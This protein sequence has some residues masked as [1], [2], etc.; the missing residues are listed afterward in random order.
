MFEMTPLASGFCIE[1]MVGLVINPCSE[2][3][4]RFDALTGKHEDAT[5]R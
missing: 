5:V 1:F 3:G 2:N 4:G